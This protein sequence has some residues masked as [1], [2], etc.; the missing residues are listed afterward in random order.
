MTE[1]MTEVNIIKRFEEGNSSEK[2]EKLLIPA[3]SLFFTPTGYVSVS[4][5]SVEL[6]KFKIPS[7]IYEV[8]VSL[9][10]STYT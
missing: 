2:L 8:R 3:S 4:C 5:P 6:L 9:R 10:M 7:D 1:V